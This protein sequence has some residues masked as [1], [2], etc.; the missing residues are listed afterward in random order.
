MIFLANFPC[1]S[2]GF[3]VKYS[4]MKKCP[5][6]FEGLEEKDIALSKKHNEAPQCPHCQQYIIEDLLTESYPTID[7][8]KCLFCGKKIYTEARICRY[9]GK[10]LD[11]VD[12]AVDDNNP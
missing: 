8:K 7:Q 4:T 9:C 10:W 11:E 5:Y 3:K 1:K 2:K 12:Q 6:C